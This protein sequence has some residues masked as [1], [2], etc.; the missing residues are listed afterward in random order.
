MPG[1]R[2]VATADTSG[3][4]LTYAHTVAGASDRVLWVCIDS[5][6]SGGGTDPTSVTYNGQAL[7]KL[8]GFMGGPGNDNNVSLWRLLAPPAGTA[9]VVVTHQNPHDITAM[10]YSLSE[11]DQTTPNGTPVLND[12]TA[13]DPSSSVPSETGD[14]VV[15]FFFG[16]SWVA[17][18]AATGALTERLENNNGGGLNSM[19]VGDA[20]G[21]ASVTA[22]WES[23]TIEVHG[24][25]NFNVNQAAA[26]GIT[27][28]RD[29]AAR[30]RL[31]VRAFRDAAT[32]LR[33][34][35]TGFR[36]AASRVRLR[37][38]AYR[39][40]ATRARLAAPAYR[41][42][43]TRFVLAVAT[44][45][46]RDAASR[47]RLRV[48]A[49]RD[50]AG[51]V[52][53]SI[54]GYRDTAARLR[55]RVGAYRDAAARFVLAVATTGYRDAAS[56]LRLRAT[57]FRDA[58][59]R[60]RVAVR[61]FRDAATLARLAVQQYRDAA[62]RLRLRTHYHGTVLATAGL[63]SYWRLGESSGTTAADELGAA[64]ATYS[65]THTLGAAGLLAQDVDTAV[66]LGSAG[67]VSAGDVYDFAGTAPFSLEAWAKPSTVDA[68]VYR[69]VFDKSSGGASE[70]YLVWIGPGGIGAARTSGGT[71]D[72]VLGGVPAVGQTS[73]IVVTYDGATL[74]LYVDGALVDEAAST[75]ALANTTRAL[76]LGA[77]SDGNAQQFLG[78]LDEAAVYDVALSAA[79]VRQHY[80]AGRH[81][82]EGYRDAA[83]RFLL[84]VGI[85]GYRDAAARVRLR[86]G[87][88][89]D[90][91]ARVRLRVLGYRDTASRV[92]LRVTGH[93]DAQARLR[94]WVQSFR[95]TQARVRVWVR[96]YRDAQSRVRLAVGS[97][98]DAGAR[99]RLRAA[100]Y[101][102]AAMRFALAVAG[103]AYRDAAV[104]LRLR[105]AG[106]RDAATRLRLSVRAYRDAASRARV[107]V[108]VHR[109]AA[110]RLRLLVQSWRDT[111][112]RVRLALLAHRDAAARARLAVPALRDTQARIRLLIVGYRDSSGRLRVAV[113]QWID[114]PARV[115]VGAPGYRD[116][117]VR[118]NVQVPDVLLRGTV[119]AGDGPVYTVI[120]GDSPLHTVTAGDGPVYTVIAGEGP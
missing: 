1:D 44:T 29:A 14:L 88:F 77:D 47:L 12:T 96:A 109:D 119:E 89:R 66:T 94:V 16:W 112:L 57:A 104:R 85:L 31:A 110:A 28:Y 7:T 87:A 41:D 92:R 74:R 108:H 21:A 70:G 59:A 34:R 103:Q 5:W 73:H 40:A 56:R 53:V 80:V 35:V 91:A 3:G 15:S 38:T 82:Q 48:S 43:A 50:A 17:E 8:A 52:R 84:T 99:L 4:S 37:V 114:V 36:D 55:L 71:N 54:L 39:D 67:Q 58:S 105:A 61:T 10:S 98:R 113:G 22:S 97:Y 32:R 6:R 11:V 83:V 42:A 60:T 86:V 46:Y 13:A 93:R 120:A 78:E 75:R 23:S 101:R 72:F 45:G 64:D 76:L 81:A 118:V 102:D 115:R 27:G 95:D 90:A 107:A 20:P 111:P 9:N 24:T 79:T 49:F 100:G 63:Q 116:A 69:R 30:L 65:G 2:A 106:T 33:L 68:L 117:A 62:G 18:V 19:I 25:V 51:R 26:G